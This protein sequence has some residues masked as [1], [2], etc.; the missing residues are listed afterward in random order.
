MN[1]EE[2]AKLSDEEKRIR[3]A[4]IM[5]VEYGYDETGNSLLYRH[6][7]PANF[8]DIYWRATMEPFDPL[9]DLNAMHEAEKVL[10]DFQLQKF[11]EHLQDIVN[12]YCVGVVPDYHRDL[13]CLAKIAH[14]SAAQ[15]ADAFLLTLG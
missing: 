15:R 8:A 12:Y 11:G 13:M 3:I 10:T 1:T 7:D 14:A 4:E 5:G 2:L 9:N 6:S